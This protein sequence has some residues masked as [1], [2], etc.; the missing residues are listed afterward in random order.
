MRLLANMLWLTDPTNTF[1]QDHVSA[2]AAT[3]INTKISEIAM[4]NE[5]SM[6][7][8]VEDARVSYVESWWESQSCEEQVVYKILLTFPNLTAEAWLNS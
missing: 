5:K 1:M 7:S 3:T 4:Y 2:K 6:M 8:A